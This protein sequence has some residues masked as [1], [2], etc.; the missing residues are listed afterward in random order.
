[1][2]ARV[3]FGLDKDLNHSSRWGLSVGSWLSQDIALAF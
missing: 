2:L 1:M 3:I